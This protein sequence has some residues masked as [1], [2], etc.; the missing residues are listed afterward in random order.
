[1][2]RG[3]KMKRWVVTPK[4]GEWFVVLR[5]DD[6]TDDHTHPLP[7]ERER[8]ADRAADRLNK[9]RESEVTDD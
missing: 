8:D 5:N 9:I 6:G 7:F 3:E 4:A 2:V 1:V